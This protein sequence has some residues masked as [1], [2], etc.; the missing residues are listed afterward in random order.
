MS[1]P[2][3]SC[4]VVLSSAAEGVTSQSFNTCYTLLNSSFNVQLASPNGK[5]VEYVN[6]DDTNRRWFNE[7]RSKSA[8]NPIP[9]ETVDAA[10]YSALVIPDS[11]GALRDL[12][13]DKDLK[14]ILAYFVK[15]KKAI[16]AVGLGVAGLFSTVHDGIWSFEDYSLTCTCLYELARNPEFPSL[17]VIPEDF[18]K[19]NGGKY[20]CSGEADSVHV[21]ID[22]HVITGQNVQSTIT[23][24]QNL[25]LL[26][27]HKTSGRLSPRV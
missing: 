15:E 17:P 11:P 18:V 12:H 26:C 7:F 5:N 13:K 1:A 23:A 20:S 9:L 16:C 27:S 22:R 21:V 3:Q 25:V 6:Q 2:R 10:R 14:Q 8:S 4:L 19:D 24:V